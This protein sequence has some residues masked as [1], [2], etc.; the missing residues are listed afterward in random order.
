MSQCDVVIIGG[1]FAGLSAALYLARARKNV[2]IVDDAQPRNR[3]S[4]ASHGFMTQDGSDPINMLAQAREQLQQYPSVH[5]INGRAAG[6]A[7][8]D[9]DF[10]VTLEDG[11]VLTSRKLVLAYGVKD[12]LPAIPGVAERWGKTVLACPYCH[13]YEFSDRQLG[14]LYAGPMSIVHAMLIADW[15]PMTLYLN[16]EAMPDESTLNRLSGFGVIVETTP[17]ISLYG[18]GTNLSSIALADGR[19]LPI[20]ALYIAPGIRMNSSIA[21]QL[22]CKVEDG[23]YGL[24]IT[25]D[26]SQMTSVAGVYAAGDIARA[27]NLLK[28]AADG[29]AAGIAAH[30]A[31]VFGDV[32]GVSV[33][34]SDMR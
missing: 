28:A 33:A 24:F 23:R 11:S 19:N 6:T 26:E 8:Q 30:A 21:D 15:G 25:T 10:T 27:N 18:Q 14:V 3:F 29:A 17:V 34:P 13:G 22:G 16:G 7:G 12:L 9:G 4:S 2:C 20:D 32:R 5:F 1:S 31:I